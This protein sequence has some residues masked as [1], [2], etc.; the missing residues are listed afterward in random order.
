MNNERCPVQKIRNFQ[1]ITM[2]PYFYR[3][4]YRQ[5]KSAFVCKC[6]SEENFEELF[7]SVSPP[8][9]THSVSHI[10]RNIKNN[11]IDFHEL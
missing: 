8:T 4:T 10:D 3:V 7:L 1:S 6:V 5:M 2:I 11:T 9:H